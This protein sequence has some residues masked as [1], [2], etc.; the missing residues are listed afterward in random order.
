[1]VSRPSGSGHPDVWASVANKVWSVDHCPKYDAPDYWILSC[2]VRDPVG[3]GLGGAGGRVRG[4]SRRGVFLFVLQVVSGTKPPL[5]AW[6]WNW[7]SVLGKAG[8]C[9]SSCLVPCRFVRARQG[10]VGTGDRCEEK[11]KAWFLE[12]SRQSAASLSAGG[13]RDRVGGCKMSEP[14]AFFLLSVWKL[15]SQEPLAACWTCWT[16]WTQ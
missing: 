9:A 13:L 1:M 11:P 8:G 5:L 4:T 6:T 14:H 2:R 3:T 16:C 15:G 12:Q 7:A 10:G